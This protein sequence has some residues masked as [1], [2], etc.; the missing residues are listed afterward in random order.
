M[1]Y[2]TYYF[3]SKGPNDLSIVHPD[4]I[5]VLSKADKGPWYDGLNDTPS[6]QSTRDR[7]AHAIR[8]R[9]W[10]KA[11]T[12]SALQD[13]IP[14]ILNY[15]DILLTNLSETAGEPVN[16][17]Q[18]FNCFT[19]DFMGDLAFGKSFGLLE[20]KGTNGS[21]R[22]MTTMH[23]NMAIVGM[24][25]HVGWFIRLTLWIPGMSGARGKFDA[26]CGEMVE[27]RKQVSRCL[28]PAIDRARPYKLL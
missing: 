4:I 1:N 12:R 23:S 22:F 25:G 17:T 3:A 9:V 2:F 14:R 5:P 6:L 7:K 26:W 11:F 10:E 27:K 28:F 21:D 20:S 19:F 16:M 15:S 18:W 8:R 24:L 13:Y